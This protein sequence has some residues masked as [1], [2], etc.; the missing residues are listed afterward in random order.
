VSNIARYHRGRTPQQ[1]H[2]PYIALDRDD[3]VLVTKLAA[4]LRVANALD[5]E[6]LGKVRD[7]RLERGP[8]AWLLALDATGDITLEQMAATARA[9]LFV[10]VFG[11]QLVI[12]HA[13]VGA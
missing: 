11:R 10:E 9:D 12:R 4:I 8:K 1:S 6:H 7:M 13:G 2:L 5:A 3:R